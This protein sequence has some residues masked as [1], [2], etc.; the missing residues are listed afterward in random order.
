[1]RNTGAENRI[2]LRSVFI[3]DVHLGSRDCRAAELLN[4]LDSIEVDNLFLVGD[5]IDLWSLR[6]SFLLAA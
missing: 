4:F 2:R 5:I 1:M 6:R 3:S